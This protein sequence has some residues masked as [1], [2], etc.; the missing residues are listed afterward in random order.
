MSEASEELAACPFCGSKKLWIKHGVG[1]LG[2]VCCRICGTLGPCYEGEDEFRRAWN[3]RA[4]TPTPPAAITTR[5][6]L[7]VAL[8]ALVARL[9]AGPLADDAEA[10]N[11]VGQAQDL[12]REAM[13]GDGE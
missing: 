4:P 1:A 7:A 3:E 5:A 9:D 13:I 6:E 11:A 2:R 10:Q 8:D 12:L